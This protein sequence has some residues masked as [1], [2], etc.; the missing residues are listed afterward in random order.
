MNIHGS[1]SILW[2]EFFIY[3]Y[4]K[5]VKMC[6]THPLLMGLYFS[7]LSY[8][9]KELIWEFTNWFVISNF[10]FKIRKERA[11]VI[12]SAWLVF[13]ARHFFSSDS[14]LLR[15][16]TSILF[17]CAIDEIQSYSLKIW[18]IISFYRHTWVLSRLRKISS[19]SFDFVSLSRWRLLLIF[20]ALEIIFR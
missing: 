15:S 6:G 16:I 10:R 13:F 19:C 4:Y 2:L 7:I 11:L 1:T 3:L 18:C 9:K 20:Q 14:H 17:V 12:S 5:R 8:T